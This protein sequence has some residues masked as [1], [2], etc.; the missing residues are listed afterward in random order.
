MSLLA[1]FDEM[2]R[3]SKWPVGAMVV[4]SNM[5]LDSLSG[6]LQAAFAK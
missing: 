5:V 2:Q 3:C 4:S 6:D 1:V